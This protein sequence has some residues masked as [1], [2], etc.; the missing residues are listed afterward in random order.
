MTVRSGCEC[1]VGRNIVRLPQIAV[2]VH[3]KEYGAR[4]LLVAAQQGA[5]FK[6][7]VGKPVVDGVKGVAFASVLKQLE[8][9]FLRGRIV[10]R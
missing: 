2:P 8:L 4:Q 3:V 10:E 7:P 9:E 5:P 6:E 1:L